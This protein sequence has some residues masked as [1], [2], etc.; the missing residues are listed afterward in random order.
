MLVWPLPAHLLVIRDFCTKN[1]G[2]DAQNLLPS[3]PMVRLRNETSLS[4]SVGATRLSQ[5]SLAV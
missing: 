4:G 3:H 1:G 5:V 2:S